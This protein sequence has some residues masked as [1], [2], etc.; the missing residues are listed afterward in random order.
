MSE[1]WL[2]FAAVFFVQLLLFIAHAHYEKKLADIP[3]ILGQSALSGLVLGVT[4]DL[5]FGKFLGICSYTLGFGP[6]FLIINGVLLYGLFAANTLLMQQ[7]RLLHFFSWTMVVAAVFEITNLFFPMWT[8]AF[9]VP[10]VEFFLVVS[11]GNFV[12]AILVA[13]VWHAFLR[14]RF[15]FIDN[16]FKN[17]F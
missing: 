7:A 3:R 12:A 13:T 8:Y 9:T 14:H 16:L 2:N 11:V 4:F 1:A 10:S 15:F 17:K 6:F 5:F